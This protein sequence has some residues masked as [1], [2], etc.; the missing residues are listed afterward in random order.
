M[1]ISFEK[2]ENV[3]DA[4]F[5]SLYDLYVMSFPA[6]ERRNRDD[7]CR[8]IVDS[9]MMNFDKIY[10]YEEVDGEK[11]ATC[12]AEKT[13]SGLMVYWNFVDFC[14]FEHLAIFP[15]YRNCGIGG[16]VL[17]NI[18]SKFDIPVVFEVEP[19]DTEIAV[20][21]IEYYKRN[22]FKVLD[23]NYI[24]SPYSGK[25]EDAIALWIMGNNISE[26][27]LKKMDFISAIRK[28]VYHV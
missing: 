6:K 12:G 16:K 13:L 4:D 15:E 3:N 5:L 19:P 25:P 26:D 8:L 28:Y 21:R 1:I 20:R 2:I 17:S 22:G 9:K 11:S 14:Y 18:N 27:E 7:L 23:T 10:V 24:Q